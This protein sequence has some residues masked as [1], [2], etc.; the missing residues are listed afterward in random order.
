[1]L[2]FAL[3][4][5]PFV[6]YLL[7]QPRVHISPSDLPYRAERYIRGCWAT[8]KSSK[9]LIILTCTVL[10]GAATIGGSRAARAQH[11]PWM[12][13]YGQHQYQNT[14]QY[15]PTA[16]PTFAPQPTRQAFPTP[17]TCPAGTTQVCPGCAFGTPPERCQCW[18]MPHST[19]QPRPQPTYKPSTGA[20][21][22]PNAYCPIPYNQPSQN[23]QNSFQKQYVQ[24][25]ARQPYQNFVTDSWLDLFS[26][27]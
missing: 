14:Y 8:M 25:Q 6:S 19:Y 23:F 18:C 21:C 7:D 24:P 12:G 26:R 22:P 16:A 11:L 20:A 9:L 10:A 27:F 2:N 3:D 4:L 5:A 15:C 17:F 1:M 13:A